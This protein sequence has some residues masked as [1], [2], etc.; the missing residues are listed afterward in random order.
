[1]KFIVEN[2]CK[3][4]LEL[5]D[6]IVAPN[7]VTSFFMR[8]LPLLEAEKNKKVLDF[9]TGTGI[10]S[11]YLAS[12]GYKD[13]VAVDESNIALD[14]AQRNVKRYRF[15]EVIDVRLLDI[16]SNIRKD[17]RFALVVTNPG[18]MIIG[19]NRTN[20]SI[21]DLLKGIDNIMGNGRVVFVQPTLANINETKELFREK[22][23]VIK[24]LA[25]SAF[26]LG[27]DKN[28]IDD[29]KFILNFFRYEDN[30]GNEHIEKVDGHLALVYEIIE[31]V[32]K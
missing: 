25:K 12:R 29:G 11:L 27:I 26:K 31:A 9:G 15:Q 22:G 4:E 14:F 21:L 30:W 18:G 32:R 28:K 1:M 19:N 5:D 24:T 20:R 13:I 3:F 6:N 7:D 17:E 16:L 23:F 10:L 8:N 2:L